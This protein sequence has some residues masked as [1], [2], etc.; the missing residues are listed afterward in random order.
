MNNGKVRIYELSKELNLDNKDI[1]EI[2]DRLNIAVKS[3]SSTIDTDQ[4]QSI[5]IAAE[6]YTPTSTGKTKNISTP[7]ENGASKPERVAKKPRKQEILALHHKRN[8][9]NSP[10]NTRSGNNAPKLLEKPSPPSPEP[11]PFQETSIQQKQNIESQAPLSEIATQPESENLERETK[12]TTDTTT[13]A[14]QPQLLSPPIR[15]SE[16][17]KRKEEKSRKQPSGFKKPQRKPGPAKEKPVQIIGTPIKNRQKD[18]EEKPATPLP[19]TKKSERP[20][21]PASKNNRRKPESELKLPK[22]QKPQKPTKPVPSISKPNAADLSYKDTEIDPDNSVLEEQE[23]E[24]AI[25][26]VAPPKRP[27]PKPKRLTTGPSRKKTEWVE[28]EEKEEEQ[29]KNKKASKGKRKPVI[30]DDD[31]DDEFNGGDSLNS[32]STAAVSMSIA[33]PPKPKSKSNQPAERSAVERKKPTPKTADRQER[34]ADKR[35]DK[36]EVVSK[37]PE[38]IVL[39]GSLT[40]RQLSELVNVPETDIIKQLFFKG[41]AVN[42]TQT[43]DEETARLVTEELG[44]EVETPEEKSAAVKETEM[45]DEAD[46]EN[47]QLRPPVVTIMGH[48]DHGKTTLLDSIRKTKVAQGEAGGITQHIGAYHVDVEYEG[49]QKQ[50]VFLDTP[51]HEAFT[52]MRA[53][54]TRVTD[55]AVL[56]VAADDGVQ[57]QTKEAISHAKAAQVPIVV[58]INKIDKPGANPDRVM[59]ELAELDLL[60]EAW[61]GDTPMVPVS[62]LKGE[63][64]DEL[65]ETILLVAALEEMSA[66]PDRLA[67]GTII[68]AN[69]DRARGPVATLL[70][71]NGTLKVG[72]VIVAGHVFGKIRAMIDDRGE[73]V[74]AAKPSFAVEIL[75]LN[76]VPPA[77]DEFDVFEN[78]KEARAIA[79]LR[80][81][82]QRQDRL[83]KALSS[84]RV[85][86]ST[87][88]E[89]AREGEL[90]ELNLI[91]KADVQGSLEA[92]M[93]LLDQLPQNEV[94][95]RILLAAPGEISETDVDLAAASGAVI[96]GFSTTLASGAREAADREGVDIREYDIIYKLKDDIQGAM[97]GLLEPEEVEEGLGTAEVRAVFQVG[98]GAVAGC[99]VQSGKIIRNRYLRVVRKGKTI[100]QGTI[101]SLKR[102]K[103]DAREV[104]A[105]YECGIGCAKFNDWQEGDIIEA[106]EM[107]MKRRTLSAK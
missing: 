69:L 84:R 55:I 16:E 80:S 62:A 87:L 101:D 88:S 13:Q 46:L 14:K 24:E 105:G 94:Q 65:L 73:K 15:R 34:S 92:I 38:K 43:I 67:K 45:L 76:Q 2:C 49:E 106:Y 52:A 37:L 83:Q 70:V 74:E 60:A 64:L 19:V 107:V 29:L 40:V 72:D 5:R 42:I 22:I 50:I 61:D 66:N 11:T 7:S 68:E 91:L 23:D 44:V 79:E 41:I 9:P 10:P 75:G 12:L 96:V 21:R 59:G 58:A 8:R 17:E 35:K 103:E 95:I 81:Q 39:P 18:G 33:R 36:K 53:R 104:N 30:I 48:V 77:G 63:N 86:L 6:K 25:A 27:Q 56:V 3:H 89:Q 98:R 28:E 85:S 54:G 93:A 82:E 32:A 90:K 20:E 78:E 97:E 102:I 31:D 100:Y 4:A 1:L 26:L 99:Y 71:Q 57:P 47:L 51:G